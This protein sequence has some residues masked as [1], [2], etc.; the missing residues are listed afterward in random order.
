MIPVHTHTHTHT[1]THTVH[2]RT[3]HT[4]THTQ[5]DAQTYQPF[6]N[7]GSSKCLIKGPKSTNGDF[8]AYK[9]GSCTDSKVVKFN[10]KGKGKELRT[11]D[12]YCLVTKRY[13]SACVCVPVCVSHTYVRAN[14]RRDHY[15]FVH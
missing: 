1:Y 13:G 3:T 7:P 15:V 9:L 6:K 5:A 12:G 10:Y 14:R 8:F 2:T 11:S 4:H